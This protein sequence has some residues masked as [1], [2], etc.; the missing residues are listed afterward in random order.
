MIVTDIVLSTK[1]RLPLLMR[2]M[3]YIFERTTSPYRLHVI[4]DASTEGNVEYLKRLRTEGRLARL[5]L[6]QKSKEMGANWNEAAKIAKSKIIVYTEDD[7][8]CP[9]LD[10]D[11]L[12]RGLATMAKYPQMGM[13]ALNAPTGRQSLRD[14][15]RVG[16]ITICNKV[17]FTLTFVRLAQMKQIIIP[18]SG[19]KLEGIVLGKHG[20]H[21]INAC[22][23][24]MRVRGFEVGYL[25]DVYCQHIG[26]I[27]ER[28]G[29]NLRARLIEPVDA[30]TLQP[31]PDW[32]KK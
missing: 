9:K 13:L 27:S 19:G 29:K 14:K 3:D 24:S 11:W 1:N 23:K 16:P 6:H 30:D 22:A 7:V 20:I 4:D 25:T 18:H 31:P 17:G 12:A 10:P 26:A 8:L 28:T 2:T 5:I 32:R 15:K 21:I